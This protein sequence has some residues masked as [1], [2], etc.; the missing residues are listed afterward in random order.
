MEFE[1]TLEAPDAPG[2]V[3]VHR[4]F[5]SGMTDELRAQLSDPKHPHNINP[6]YIGALIE[7]EYFEINQYGNLEH[8]RLKRVRLDLEK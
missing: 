1:Y 5:C 4:G 2:F 8:P 3:S 7:V 6:E